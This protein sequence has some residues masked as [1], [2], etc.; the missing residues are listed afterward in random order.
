M[1]DFLKHAPSNLDET[2]LVNSGISFVLM[3]MAFSRGT[4]E[5]VVKH[6]NFGVGGGSGA[7]LTSNKIHRATCSFRHTCAAAMPLR[8]PNGDEP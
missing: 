3:A 5:Q 8:F 2:N 4:V 1:A 7:G 6:G